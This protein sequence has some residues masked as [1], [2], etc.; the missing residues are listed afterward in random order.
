ME[1]V[2]EG[3]GVVRHRDYRPGDALQGSLHGLAE[4]VLREAV[5][6]L[7]GLEDTRLQPRQ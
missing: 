5:R 7:L 3:L 6:P 1:V 2:F 4:A